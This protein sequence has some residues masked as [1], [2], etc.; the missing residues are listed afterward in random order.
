M[1]EDHHQS[2][3]C[4]RCAAVTCRP[5]SWPVLVPL[6]P[7]LFSCTCT[8]HSSCEQLLAAVMEGAGSCGCHR[9][10]CIQLLLS[11]APLLSCGLAWF[12]FLLSL[13]G[14]LHPCSGGSCGSCLLSCPGLLGIRHCLPPCH[15]HCHHP[16]P[17]RLEGCLVW[18]PVW[19]RLGLAHG[20]G[21][22][23]AHHYL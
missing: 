4:L 6:V 15:P 8:L 11:L 12:L 13:C 19:A 23:Q 10:V 1:C 14:C 22:G 17:R 2:D 7:L 20:F 18:Q 21:L 5:R 16:C 9:L 3:C